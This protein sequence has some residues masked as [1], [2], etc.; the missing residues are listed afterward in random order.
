MLEA[1]LLTVGFLICFAIVA[2]GALI[3]TAAAV[4]VVA[5]ALII[6]FFVIFFLSAYIAGVYC[7]MCGRIAKKLPNN[8]KLQKWLQRQSE[9]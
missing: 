2:F 7:R 4:V 3:G 9:L 8:S 1:F 6:C 5:I